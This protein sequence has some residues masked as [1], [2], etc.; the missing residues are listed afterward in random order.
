M[1]PG[2]CL[3]ILIWIQA[4]PSRRVMQASVPKGHNP[5]LSC[6][7]C[8]CSH[9]QENISPIFRCL[10]SFVLLSCFVSVVCFCVSPF[11]RTDA[12]KLRH[13]LVWSDPPTPTPYP[14]EVTLLIGKVCLLGR[15]KVGQIPRDDTETCGRQR[16]CYASG[17][18]SY[19]GTH[20]LTH[21][22]Y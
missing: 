7:S 22:S 10:E 16:S 11:G 21:G 3:F 12:R 8:V 15:V 2:K 9:V 13:Q 4:D 5:I 1:L 14:P 18:S 20:R 19:L 17:N 6:T